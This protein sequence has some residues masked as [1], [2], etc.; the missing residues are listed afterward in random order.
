VMRWS[1]RCGRRR[2]RARHSARTYSTRWVQARCC[3]RRASIT[4]DCAARCTTRSA[5]SR[6]RAMYSA[7]SDRQQHKQRCVR[8]RVCAPYSRTR[9]M[10]EYNSDMARLE[11]QLAEINSLV[12]SAPSLA[13]RGDNAVA[14]RDRTC[15]DVDDVGRAERKHHQTQR[16][17]ESVRRGTTRRRARTAARAA[18][19][20]R[21]SSA[22]G[23]G[24]CGAHC[25][26]TSRHIAIV[27]AQGARMHSV[28]V[29]VL[30]CR[31]QHWSMRSRRWR[32][33]SSRRRTPPA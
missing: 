14:V 3:R 17:C 20:T 18:P 7:T 12:P 5:R 6:R 30:L 21:V 4:R 13:V 27:A 29:I 19:L 15:D 26:S 23:G 10:S 32:C 28:R 9:Q 33:A 22:T 25:G 11:A 24:A 31:H 2:A 8:A 1:R 16:R